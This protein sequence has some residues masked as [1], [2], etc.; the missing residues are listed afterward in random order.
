MKMMSGG[1]DNK[2]TCR[3]TDDESP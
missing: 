1:D 2:D 3:P